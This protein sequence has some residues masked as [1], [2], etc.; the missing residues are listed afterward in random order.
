MARKTSSSKDQITGEVHK[1]ASNLGDRNELRSAEFHFTNGEV[2]SLLPE[3]GDTGVY[4]VWSK[5]SE[6]GEIL[7][8]MIG[9]DA[10]EI[11]LCGSVILGAT[12]W[13]SQTMNIMRL[14]LSSEDLMKTFKEAL[15]KSK[16][17]E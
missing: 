12:D 14:L 10:V 4:V 15:E 1:D 16:D 5:E 17:S 6:E 7:F 2:K 3:R 8:G 13:A 11:A 9:E